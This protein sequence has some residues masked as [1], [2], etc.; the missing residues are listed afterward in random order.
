MKKLTKIIGAAILLM[1]LNTAVYGQQ[2]A[3][4]AANAEVQAPLTVDGPTELDF[5][6]VQQGTNKT[7]HVNGTGNDGDVVIGQFTVGGTDGANITLNFTTLENLSDGTNTLTIDYASTDY[8]TWDANGDN[9]NS[10]NNFDPTSET[11]TATLDTDG[12]SVFIGGQ[13]QPDAGQVTGTY[14]GTITLEATYN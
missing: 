3:S 4:I 5:G 10:T 8:A 1:G 2:S 14:T 12:I 6:N 13:A 7:V 9:T 11:P